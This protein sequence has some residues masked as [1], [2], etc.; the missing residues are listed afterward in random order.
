VPIT[1]SVNYIYQTN[2]FYSDKQP[3]SVRKLLC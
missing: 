2:R 1:K 3:K